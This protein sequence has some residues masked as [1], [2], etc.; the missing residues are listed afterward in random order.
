MVK[1]HISF[2]KKNAK[3]NKLTMVAGII[4]GLIIVAVIVY[5]S[6]QL[7]NKATSKEDLS[8]YNGFAFEHRVTE[9]QDFWIT[10]VQLSGDVY[11]VP[12]YNHPSGLEDYVYD[13]RVTE[14]LLRKGIQEIILAVHPDA[15]S[16][17]VLAGINIARVTG[18]FYGISTSSAL[19]VPE[20]ETYDLNITQ[21][22]CGDATGQKPIIWLTNTTVEPSVILS[23]DEHFCIYVSGEGDNILAAADL[24]VYKLLGIMV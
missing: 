7:I 14:Y 5:G 2:N 13:D 3:E 8:V 1:K 11:E 20:D 18:K 17:P 9:K 21:V 4:L 10:H 22:N 15:G 16:T 12:F 24:L 23:D 6:Y 19:Y